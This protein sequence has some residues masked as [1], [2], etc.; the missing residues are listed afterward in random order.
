[1]PEHIL[2]HYPFNFEDILRFSHK[3]KVKI[4]EQ[5]STQ[6]LINIRSEM[7]PTGHLVINEK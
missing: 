7:L 5:L 1:M 4:F 2:I 6:I 3:L